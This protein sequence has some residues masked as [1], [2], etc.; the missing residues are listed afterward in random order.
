MTILVYSP[1]FTRPRPLKHQRFGSL[2]VA[3]GGKLKRT[4]F[5]CQ[6]SPLLSL[7]LPFLAEAALDM[8]NVKLPPPIFMQPHNDEL[9]VYAMFL[10][11][12]T[13]PSLCL[14]WAVISE[15]G[16][17]TPCMNCVLPELGRAA[18]CHTMQA[19]NGTSVYGSD[20]SATSG[21]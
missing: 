4:V 21:Q 8:R 19:H 17:K 14:G 18:A 20:Q 12:P 15:A 2:P 9:K 5:H 11:H 13:E 1:M 3:A 7:L 10:G 6:K 16:F